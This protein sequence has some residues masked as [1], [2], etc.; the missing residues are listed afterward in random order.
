MERPNSIE[1]CW[2]WSPLSSAS[3]DSF[4]FL[5][6]K[7][8]SRG[9]PSRRRSAAAPTAA[10]FRRAAAGCSSLAV[11]NSSTCARAFTLIASILVAAY[12]S[13]FTFA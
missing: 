8:A 7:S 4:G 2:R 5:R 9:G 12:L 6:R 3:T 10:A 1:R 11:A 13:P